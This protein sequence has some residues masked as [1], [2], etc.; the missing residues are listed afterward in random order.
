[1]PSAR[2]QA[3]VGLPAAGSWPKMC[4]C[5]MSLSWCSL[6]E[7]KIARRPVKLLSRVSCLQNLRK[8]GNPAVSQPTTN[9]RGSCWTTAKAIGTRPLMCA[10]HTYH[11]ARTAAPGFDPHMP[12]CDRESNLRMRSST[13]HTTSYTGTGVRTCDPG[14]TARFRL[15]FGRIVVGRGVGDPSISPPVRPCEK[16]AYLFHS[17]IKKLIHSGPSS[18]LTSPPPLIR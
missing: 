12:T 6:H 10:N 2:S 18:R 9:E 5:F 13:A 4:H 17:S 14:S 15:R 11:D 8:H 1:M 7:K 16:V 3:S